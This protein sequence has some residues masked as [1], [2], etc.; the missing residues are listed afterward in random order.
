MEATKGGHGGAIIFIRG[1][2]SQSSVWERLGTQRRVGGK[3]ITEL[4]PFQLQTP[5][6]DLTAYLNEQVWKVH[7]GQPNYHKKTKTKTYKKKTQPGVV[8]A[9][10]RRR[11]ADLTEIEASLD[12]T[13]S[14]RTAK[15]TQ[16]N[17]VFK[18][19]KTK[20]NPHQM[21]KGMLTFQN[22]VGV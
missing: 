11:Q 15:T 6:T 1:V 20:P 14:S 16:R 19:S 3:K 2:K 18:K 9:S 5:Q 8:V 21:A 13:S 22:W 17:P 12:Y 7:Q 10:R 4:T